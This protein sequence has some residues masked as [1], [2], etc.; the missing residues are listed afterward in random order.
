MRLRAKGQ[1]VKTWIVTDTLFKNGE[2]FTDPVTVPSPGG[3]LTLSKEERQKSVKPRFT[4][5][6]STEGGNT[7]IVRAAKATSIEK[8]QSLYNALLLNPKNMGAIH[9]CAFGCTIT[10]T[11]G[12]TVWD[13]S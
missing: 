8:C 12:S 6:T 7:F 3:L 11:M 9:N 4:E 5:A 2:R 1:N 13:V 10:S